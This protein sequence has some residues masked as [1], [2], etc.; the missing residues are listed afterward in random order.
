LSEIDLAGARL[1]TSSSASREICAMHLTLYYAPYT[2]AL[3]PYVTL[4]EAGADFS[5]VNVN[6]RAGQ[7][8]SAEFMRVNLKAKVPVLVIDGSPL[9]ENLALQVWI[10]RQFPQAKLLPGSPADEVK[11]LSLM[12]WFGTTIHP[13]LTPNARPER[14]CDL[15]NSAESVKR[16]ANAALFED[17]G[18]ADEMLVGREWFFSHFTAVDAYFF[19]CFRRAVTFKLDLSAFAHCM[20]HFERMQER[21]SVQKVLAYELKVL[22]EFARGA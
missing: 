2:C 9:T 20:A 22:D 3:V 18:I 17:F 13:H 15:P 7:N 8:R 11:A 21:A 14:Y 19:W 6:T 12:S 16:L 4:T 5:V 1:V 10:S